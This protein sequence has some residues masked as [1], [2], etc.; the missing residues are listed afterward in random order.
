MTDPAQS[1][2]PFGLVNNR[3]VFWNL[4]APALVETALARGE[5]ILTDR[6]ALAVTT[7]KR[8]GRSPK[9]RFV[10]RDASTEKEVWWGP[11]NL[12]IEPDAF[13]R[14]LDRVRAYLQGRSLFVHDA[15]TC[16]DPRYRLPLRVVTENAWHALF[17]HCLFR[18]LG[19]A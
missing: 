1:V 17:A 15:Y 6:G 14:L 10:V 8:T 3:E 4:S 18:R 2:L 12:P 7:G 5:G 19:P 9:D 11:I 16:A 13:G